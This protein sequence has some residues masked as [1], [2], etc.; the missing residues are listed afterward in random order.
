MTA[1]FPHCDDLVLH[2]D[3]EYCNEYPER[4]RKRAA[5]GINFT[6]EYDP[7]KK[8]CPSEERRS[9]EIINRWPGN[10]AKKIDRPLN[11]RG[12]PDAQ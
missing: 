9:L 6:G 2:R 5:D 8:P 1:P 3:C 11:Y 7:S 10:R 12:S 4:Q